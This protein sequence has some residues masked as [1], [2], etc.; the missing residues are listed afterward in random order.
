MGK[1]KVLLIGWDAAD[2]KLIWPLIKKG[3]MPALKSVIERG[4]YGNMSTMNPPYSPMLWTSVATGKTP[5]KHG[6]MGFIEVNEKR[7]GIRPVTVKSRKSRALW[8]IF[9]NQDLKS[10]LIGWWPSFP[11]EPINGVVVSDA[12]QKI[13]VILRHLRLNR[14]VKICFLNN[15]HNI[16]KFN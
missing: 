12:F 10:N 6:V 3:Q 5:D 4:V 11:A 7:S 16:S 13:H 9:H 15:L 1:P 8:N 2:W 14:D